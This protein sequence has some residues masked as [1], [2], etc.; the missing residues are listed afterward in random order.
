MTQQINLLSAQFRKQRRAA[1][2]AAILG[3]VFALLVAFGLVAY[4]YSLLQ[5][6]ALRTELAGIEQALKVEQ[7]KQIKAAQAIS[8]RTKDPA[9]EVEVQRMERQLDVRR[10]SLEML[11]SGV[12][13]NTTGFS[14][15]MLGL[16]RQTIDGL[17][18]TG[19]TIA[20]AG[21]EISLEGRALRADL[22]PAYIKR[23]GQEPA[24]AGRDF[25]ALTIGRP[26]ADARTD[27]AET[28]AYLAFSL[29]ARTADPGTAKGV[30]LAATGRP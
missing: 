24:F 22:V 28:G 6:R 27:A 7:D 2:S 15:Q 1:T 9:L 30:E 8:A 13:G 16:A 20:G 11:K 3:S 5:V 14:P 12:I 4:G 21:A 25:S 23:L 17:W 26:K 18:L 10:A 19:F 29:A